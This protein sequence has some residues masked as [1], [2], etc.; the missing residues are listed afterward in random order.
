[1][2]RGPATALGLFSARLSLWGPPEFHHGGNVES[3]HWS[4]EQGATQ[5]DQEEPS[6]PQW[7]PEQQTRGREG[8]KDS[9]STRD[10]PRSPQ[11][12]QPRRGKKDEPRQV[13]T[14][15]PFAP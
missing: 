3:T 12:R 9:S 6:T 13:Q 7:P 8:P 14:A 1:M 4:R 10:P 5:G 2:R 11:T 15:P